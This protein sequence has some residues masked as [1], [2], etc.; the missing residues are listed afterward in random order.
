MG[1][2][3]SIERPTESALRRSLLETTSLAARWFEERAIQVRR[4]DWEDEPA[5]TG[6]MAKIVYGFFDR[7]GQALY[8]GESGTT[9]KERVRSR[10]NSHRKKGWWHS[11]E[12]LKVAPVTERTD[13]LTLELLLILH[14]QPRHNSKPGPRSIKEMFC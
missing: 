5:R 4:A 3:S 10:T 6:S 7:E 1:N 13:R 9:M 12:F 2:T 8:I 14:H 11:W